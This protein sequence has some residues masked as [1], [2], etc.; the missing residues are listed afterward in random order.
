MP[1]FDDG[2]NKKKE[3]QCLNLIGLKKAQRLA[4]NPQLKKFD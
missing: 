4:I 1:H 3:H 2:Q